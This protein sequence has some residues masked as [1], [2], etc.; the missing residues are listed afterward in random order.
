[1]HPD[2]SQFPDV[3]N[4]ADVPEDFGRVTPEMMDE[5]ARHYSKHKDK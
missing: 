2:E 3:N 5:L 1:M 4:V